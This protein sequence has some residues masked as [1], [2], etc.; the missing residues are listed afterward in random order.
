MIISCITVQT[1]KHS[2][3]RIGVLID[4]VLLKSGFSNPSSLSRRGPN[5]TKRP[6]RED[7]PNDGNMNDQ[8]ENTQITATQQ[9]SRCLV[10]RSAIVP[11]EDGICGWM[12]HRFHKEVMHVHGT[13]TVRW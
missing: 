2:H 9:E 8:F 4:T 10:T 1:H 12:V 3:E 11:Y 7:A 13:N 6:K 5:S